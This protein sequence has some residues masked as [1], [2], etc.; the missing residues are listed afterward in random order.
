M[1]AT[2]A[3]ASSAPSLPGLQ[4]GE[5]TIAS[6]DA[7]AVFVFDRSGRHLRTV[8]A[9]TKAIV[10]RFGYDAAGRLGRSRTATATPPS[11]SATQPATPTAI[12]GPYG[13]TTRLQVAAS[14]YLTRIEN[15]AGERMLIAY[16][17]G[18]LFTSLTDPRDGA[19]AV[20]VRLARRADAGRRARRRRADARAHGQGGA[21]TV[22]RTTAEGRATSYRV[23]RTPGGSLKRTV[24]DPAGTS[25]V[26]VTGNDGN[27]T[28]TLPDGM[29][30]R[31]RSVP[32]RASACRPRSSSAYADTCRAGC[33]RR[34]ELRREVMLDDPGDL[35]SVRRLTRDLDGQRSRSTTRIYDGATSRFIDAAAERTQLSTDVDAQRRPLRER[36]TG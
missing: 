7:Q 4:I 31:P 27:T 18:G 2:T 28:V 23:E 5:F 9:L 25:T 34:T 33:A 35:L 29:R 16:G 3:S 8:D 10:V 15:P 21:V 24:T 1:P 36:S 19:H 11:S 6:E 12:V 26:T 22:R 32:T 20:R 17:T 30:R 13:Q 14:G